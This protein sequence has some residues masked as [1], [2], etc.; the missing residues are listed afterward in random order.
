MS[1]FLRG[2]TLDFGPA[3]PQDREAFARAAWLAGRAGEVLLTVAPRG[4]R[5]IGAASLTNVDWRRREARLVAWWAPDVAASPAAAAEVV[6]VLTRYASDE[7]N[8]EALSAEPL[9][10]DG[11]AA[12]AAA[13]WEGR[14]WRRS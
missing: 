4:G 5:P 12:L 11:L 7:L 1:V 8:L 2:P 9:T 6:S 3:S 10:R 14:T 13:G